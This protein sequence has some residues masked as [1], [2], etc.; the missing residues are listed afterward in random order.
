[1]SWVATAIVGTGIASS[2]VSSKSA[3][4]AADASKQASG[5]AADSALEAAKI[6][7]MSEQEKLEYLKQINALPQEL[8][9]KALRQLGDYYQVPGQPKDQ[10]ALID[11][12]LKS[13]LYASIM[14]TK[15]DALS[16]IARYASATGGLR[17]GNSQVAFGRESERISNKALLDSYDRAQAD[18]R[19]NT[20]R[21][22][23]GISGLAGINTGSADIANSIA[24]IG[25]I[26]AAGVATAGEATAGG[27]LGAAQ[28]RQQ[29]TQN[30]TN[31]LLGI[32]GLGLKAYD[33]GLIHF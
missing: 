6:Q 25:K 33:A 9:D 32:A 27:M 12:A 20:E 16:G 14:G 29:G 5:V 2:Y 4:K 19:Y 23:A 18:D 22:L 10:Q 31:N 11:E 1:M 13:P 26:N 8:R 30:T 21:S 24:N 15:D 28:A 17:S 7:A 3:N